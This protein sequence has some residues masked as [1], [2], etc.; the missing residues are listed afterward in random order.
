MNT[1]TGWTLHR[2]QGRKDGDYHAHNNAEQLYYFLTPAK[3]LLDGAVISV[4]RGDCVHIPPNM[5]HQLLNADSDDW[6]EHLLV[7][8]PVAPPLLEAMGNDPSPWKQT[9]CRNFKDAGPAVSHDFAIIWPLFRG[10]EETAYSRETA[11]NAIDIEDAP[12]TLLGEPNPLIPSLHLLVRSP[13][14]FDTLGCLGLQ[15]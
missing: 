4:E 2:V 3:M 11:K 9:L 6:V 12:K 5:L 13:A 14:C 1:M 8:C 15:V 7:T 10:F